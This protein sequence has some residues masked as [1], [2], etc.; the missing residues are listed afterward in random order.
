MQ[1]CSLEHAGYAL[2]FRR[3]R[4]TPPLHGQCS[5]SDGLAR[6]ATGTLQ[7]SDAAKRAA[8]LASTPSSHV[9]RLHAPATRPPFL[10]R[11]AR[12]RILRAV[13]L[14]LGVWRLPLC[15]AGA[16]E[17]RCAAE[18]RHARLRM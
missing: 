2:D 4:F 8:R 9:R 3:S 13:F 16:K 15:S 10:G 17:K 11:G 1:Q 18:A 14:Q 12:V 5:P 7:R 6:V